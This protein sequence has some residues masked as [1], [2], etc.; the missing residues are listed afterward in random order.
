MD[1]ITAL[2]SRLAEAEAIAEEYKGKTI[3]NIV[4]QMRDVLN[5]KEKNALSKKPN[6]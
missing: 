4:R 3:E 6:I 1:D 2:K 5:E